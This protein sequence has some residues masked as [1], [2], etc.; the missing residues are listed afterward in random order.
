MIEIN[1]F[2]SNKYYPSRKLG[3]YACIS[4]RI[5]T[6]IQVVRDYQINYNWYNEPFAVSQYKAFILRHAWLNLWD[7]RMTTGR[8]NQVAI[9]KGFLIFPFN[10]VKCQKEKNRNYTCRLTKNFTY[11]ITR[12]YCNTNA[13]L[14]H[15]NK[16]TQRTSKHKCNKAQLSFQKPLF[17]Y[18]GWSKHELIWSTKDCFTYC[19]QFAHVHP[20][21]TVHKMNPRKR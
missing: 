8:I 16:L 5:T 10:H 21:C 14:S 17:T 11:S 19:I 7:E 20:I 9:L 15:I 3:I 12:I 18:S 6:V 13:E 2:Q 1:W 4:S